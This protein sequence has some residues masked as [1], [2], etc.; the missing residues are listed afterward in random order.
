MM[1]VAVL[2]VFGTGGYVLSN[3]T[4][5]LLGLFGPWPGAISEFPSVYAWG[6]VIRSLGIVALLAYFALTRWRGWWATG[7]GQAWRFTG[8]YILLLAGLALGSSVVSAPV[9]MPERGA[10]VYIPIMGGLALFLGVRILRKA[11]RLGR[12]AGA[13]VAEATGTPRERLSEAGV[14]LGVGVLVSVARIMALA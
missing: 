12:E 2:L 13:T 4:N 5:V 8:S 14:V 7:Q 10:A 6:C 3:W 11:I 1:L 9:P